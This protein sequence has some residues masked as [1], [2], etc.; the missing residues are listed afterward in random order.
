MALDPKPS[1]AD[2]DTFSHDETAVFTGPQKVQAIDQASVLLWM[3]TKVDAFT[4]DE[5]L[6]KI[7]RWAV[8]DMAWS[9]LVKTENK[10]AMNSPFSSERIGSYSYSKALRQVQAGQGTGVEW[11]D[12]AV[13]LFLGEAGE[14][15]VWVATEHVF[16]QP[17]RTDR[18][19]TVLSDPALYGSMIWPP[20]DG[21]SNTWVD[22]G[23]P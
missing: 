2:L 3:A 14:G 16:E 8:L 23:T 5:T 1:G 20:S 18:P 4:G 10:T 12:V 22:G 7:I 9:L 21:G 13:S 17:Y 6:D 15:A 11:F 19:A